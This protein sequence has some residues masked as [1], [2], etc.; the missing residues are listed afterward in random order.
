MRAYERFLKY[1]AIHTRSD[2]KTG[3]TPSF[4]GEFDLAHVLVDEM[5]AMGIEDAHVD[6]K[7]YV[8]GTL[9]A[10]PGYENAPAIGLCAH[11]DTAD[12]NGKDV[13]PRL[14]ENYDG[15]LIPLGSTRF[16]LDPETF[17]DLKEMVGKTVIVTDG[18]TLLG[19]DDKA[20]IAEI[21]TAA[22]RL[23]AENIPH[24]K[25][26]FTFPP[27]EEIGA[28]AKDLDL[29]KLGADLAYTLDAGQTGLIQYETFNAAAAEIHI[30]GFGVHPGSSKNTMINALL[31]AYELNGMLPSGETPRD[32][33]GYEGFF[34]LTHMEGTVDEAVMEY[35]I[36]DHDKV[37]FEGRKKA[38]LHIAELLND[39]YGRGTVEIKLRDQYYN[40]AEI[41]RNHPEM[42]TM[43]EE[44]IRDAGL[45][46]RTLPIR[47][48]TDG[49]QL[50]FRGLPCPDL[51]AGYYGAHGQYEHVAVEDMDV[52]TDVIVNLIRRYA[53]QKK[54]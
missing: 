4:A 31:V 26:C 11:L 27:D 14:V 24:G 36:R 47:G 13:K 49:A 20:G 10:S 6:D 37:L 22:E 15:G 43:A 40:M 5:K 18:T 48:G 30:T 32:T 51:S 8:Y 35:I 39:K 38:M 54:C 19:G 12:Y 23:M 50:S 16:V 45:T 3:T 33:T 28:G 29:E 25:I 44:A 53:D 7:C 2:E 9:P 34:H 17:P 42:I 46:P 41:I 1:V 52:C 21:L